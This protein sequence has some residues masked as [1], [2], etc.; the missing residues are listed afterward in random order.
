MPYLKTATPAGCRCLRAFCRTS[1]PTNRSERSSAGQSSRCVA[2]IRST[3]SCVH[4]RDQNVELRRRQVQ[5]VGQRGVIEQVRFP[6]LGQ[7]P[8]GIAHERGERAEIQQLG[9]VGIGQRGFGSSEGVRD[10]VVVQRLAAFAAASRRISAAKRFA[11]VL[12]AASM[13]RA[14][15]NI[16]DGMMF[17]SAAFTRPSWSNPPIFPPAPAGVCGPAPPETACRAS[18]FSTRLRPTAFRR[19]PYAI[20]PNATAPGVTFHQ[21]GTVARKHHLR[22]QVAPDQR[23]FARSE[24]GNSAPLPPARRASPPATRPVCRRRWRASRCPHLG[25]S[26]GLAGAR[27]AR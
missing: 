22:N 11:V 9:R 20:P 19:N 2:K 6:A 15:T 1:S 12:S 24:P 21:R 16:S 26:P 18:G 27:Q 5:L 23:L 17:S 13:S 7:N 3:V 10:G 8:A 14:S 25:R 4:C